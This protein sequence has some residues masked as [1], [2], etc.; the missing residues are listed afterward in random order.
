MLIVEMEKILRK[1]GEII[2]NAKRSDEMVEDKEGHA[3]FV[4]TYDK[5]VQSF[6]KEELLKIEPGSSFIGEEGEMGNILED[7]LTFIVDPIDGTTN[8]IKDY[9][10]SAISIGVLKDGEPYV[11][12]VYNPYLGE[13]FGAQKDLGSFMNGKKLRV[14]NKPLNEGIVIV[15][16]APYYEELKQKTF[17]MAFD[18]FNK[19]LDIRRSGSAALDLCNIAAG[20]A[21]LFFEC[22]LQPW[23]YAAGY[24]IVTEAG[25]T[26]ENMDGGK[27]D[28]SKACGI[29]AHNGLCK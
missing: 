1:A 24:V 3:N 6:L 11:G 15:G 14:S 26:V 9:K 16:T 23:D 25:G 13:M 2:L 4:T 29:I 27:V 8:F 7:G 17:D 22:R 21:E 5:A 19:S 18:Y 10:V 28:F 12:C 20:R